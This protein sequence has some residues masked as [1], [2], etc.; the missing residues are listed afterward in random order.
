MKRLSTLLA[1]RDHL[2]K[3]ARLANLASAYSTLCDFAERI[4]RAQLAGCVT[5]KPIAPEE[6]R[7]CVTLT[8]LEYSQAV[9]EEH[10]TDEDLIE[11]AEVIAFRTGE[12]NA[13]V[14]FRLEHFTEA[15][16]EPLRAQLEAEGVQ[17]D[18]GDTPVEEPRQS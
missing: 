15:F 4:D 17:I 16:V 7:Y 3:Q 9:I 8:A 14:T 1:N 6:E 2:L 5:L 13:E 10:F 11:L 12:R 18:Q